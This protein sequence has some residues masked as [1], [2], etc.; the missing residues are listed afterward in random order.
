MGRRSTSYVVESLDGTVHIPLPCLIECNDIPNNREE[1][2]M[3]H[4]ALHH[5]HLKKVTHLIPELAPNAHILMLLGWDIIRVHKVHKQISGP[6][7]EPF[8]Q[9]LDLGWVIVGNV[10]LGGV[11]KT[12]MVNAFYTNTTE[13][14]RPTLFRPCPNLFNIKEKPFGIQIPYDNTPQP[15]DRFSCEWNHL[16][17]CVFEQ[18]KNDHQV[19]LSIQEN[20]F[21]K[22]MKEGMKKDANNRWT[23]PLPYKSPHQRL[24]NNRP[25]A[26]NQ[27]KSLIC[28]FNRKPEMR[29]NFITFIEKSSKMVMLKLLLL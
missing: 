2:P 25:Q 14:G 4:A 10:C 29:D 15:S 11:H 24:P 7:D 3:P 5:P 17:C 9:K 23:T 21:M 26:M 28:N 18:A 19:S 6:H 16:G 22:I 13:R 20:A 1:I 27:F 8:A 12:F